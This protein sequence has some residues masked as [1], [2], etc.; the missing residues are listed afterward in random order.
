MQVL[1]QRM[2]SLTVMIAFVA[3]MGPIA[4]ASDN[5]GPTVQEMIER[6][7]APPVEIP[8]SP[9]DFGK[10]LNFRPTAAPDPTTHRCKHD[11]QADG[12]FGKNLVPYS[13]QA[14][15]LNLALHFELGSDHL[16]GSDR[17]Q[18]T[19]LA[20][21]MQSDALRGERFAISGHT[22]KTGNDAVNEPLSCARAISARAYLIELGINSDRLDAYGFGS[23][24]PIENEI[25]SPL[26]RR[27]EIRR[28]L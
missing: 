20:L 6:L 23:T 13:V 2:A 9:E 24:S 12:E 19:R 5:D 26:N 21:A 16:S 8:T 14:P 27:V 10:G 3:G 1:T 11:L 18:L 15:A 17:S 7:S 22:D 28:A 25:E 4:Q